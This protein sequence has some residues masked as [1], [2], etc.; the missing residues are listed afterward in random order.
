MTHLRAALVATTSVVMLLGGCTGTGG[1]G[2]RTVSLEQAVQEL[3]TR[4]DIDQAMA[5]YNQLVDQLRTELTTATGIGPWEKFGAAS[6]G[7]CTE[8]GEAGTRLNA[9]SQSTASWGAPGIPEERWPQALAVIK[10]VTTAAGF[11]TIEVMR[12]QPGDHDLFI[13]GP[14]KSVLSLGTA[15]RTGLYLRTGCH[16]LPGKPIS[17]DHPEKS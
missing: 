6:S 17:P 13:H 5:G 1:N 10:R 7:A 8:Y 9:D 12:D 4:P 15:K 11:T 3:K 16:R 2:G 14:H